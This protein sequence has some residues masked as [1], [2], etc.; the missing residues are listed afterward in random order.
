[1]KIFQVDSFTEKPFK[2]NPAGVCLLENEQA[3]S[4][5]QNIA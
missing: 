5:M 3:E 4:W 2:G 1:M